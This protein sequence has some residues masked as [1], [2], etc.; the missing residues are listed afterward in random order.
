MSGV[1]EKALMMLS[2]RFLRLQSSWVNCF[3]KKCNRSISLLELNCICHQGFANGVDWAVDHI[4]S[5][6][7]HLFVSLT[8]KN[9]S[10][11]SFLHYKQLKYHIKNHLNFCEKETTLARC[12]C[13]NSKGPSDVVTQYRSIPRLCNYDRSERVTV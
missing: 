4:G 10:I 12:V 1:E 3:V 13:E 2:I 11:F 6:S 8:L 5:I 7:F 9:L